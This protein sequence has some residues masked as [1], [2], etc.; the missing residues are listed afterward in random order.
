MAIED[1]FRELCTAAGV[2]PDVTSSGPPT[3][4]LRAQD[5]LEAR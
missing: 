5:A 4:P 3:L 1:A 2:T